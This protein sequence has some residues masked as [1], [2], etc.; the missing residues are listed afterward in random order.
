M[1]R[2]RS[3]D[4]MKRDQ[5]AAC[6][7]P[8]HQS[9]PEPYV[10]AACH[11]NAAP[12]DVRR[13]TVRIA[14]TV[15]RSG[16]SHR[17]DT[18]RAA[19]YRRA[20]T[21]LP[22]GFVVVVK[23]ECET[24]RMVAPLLADLAGKVD[25]TVYTQ[26]DPDVPDRHRGGPRRRPRR[27]LAP[28][29]RDGSDADPR[30]R[31]RRRSSAPSAGRVPTGSAITGLDGLGEDLP[32]MRPGCGSLSVDPDRVDELRVRF[33]GGRLR[34]RRVELA[35]LEDDIEAMFTRG[36]TDGLPVVPPTEER[37]LRHARGHDAGAGR[38][39]RH[40]A[41]RPRRRHGREGRHRRRDGGLPAR[42][43]AVGAHRGRGDLHR[44]VQHPRRAGDDDAGR[45]GDHRQRTGHPSDRDE[46][47][48]Q[49]ARPGQPGQPDDRPGG[50]A[51]RAQRRRRPAGRRRPGRPR[52][53]GQAV[54]LLRRAR[55]TRRS[56]RSPRAAARRPAPTPSRCS[57]ARGR[58]ASSTRSR[59][60]RRAWPESLAAC[61]R[62][63]HHPKLVLG[64]DA[65]LVVGPEHG[66]VFAEAGLGS[67][68]PARRARRR[69]ADP[70]WRAGRAAPAGSPR[71]CRSRSPTRPCPSS[72]PAAS[73]SPTRVAA[74]GCSRPSSV[75]GPTA[76]SAASR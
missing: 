58:A 47:R 55:R 72:G 29:H 17:A 64:F 53:P 74:P 3:P 2:G 75:A 8:L 26:D 46:R 41:A 31:R 67:R 16:S 71:A 32:V 73:C 12:G 51:R 10:P 59:G 44:R 57:P 49:R 61:L 39:R 11:V 28:R 35:E 23:E 20:M 65:V 1:A 63:L 45:P 18:G 5:H 48:R 34:S 76:P 69:P 24:C 15:G 66:R 33:E 36:W 38:D 62:T 27:Q 6:R 37:V 54:V 50:A 22:D 30:R 52:Q 13:T 14:H 70:G 60:A 42:V 7:P 4:A 25:L 43:P 21:P 56:A 9:V 19:Q 40:R 68:S